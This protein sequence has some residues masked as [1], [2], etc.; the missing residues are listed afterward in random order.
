[1]T[2]GTGPR[3]NEPGLDTGSSVASVRS[4][5]DRWSP[6]YDWNP[7][8]ALVRPA[9]RRAVTAMA[10]SA[11]DTV[12]DMGTG[13]GANLPLLREAVGPSGHVIGVDVSPGMLNRAR[14]RVDRSGWRNVTLVEGDIREPP[15]EGPVAGI[16]S[17]FVVVIY[18]DPDRLIESWV[19]RLNPGTVANLYAGP[20]GRWYGPAV[21]GLLSVYLRVF[22]EGW[23]LTGDGP[24]PLRVIASRGERARTALA[25]RSE[26][27]ETDDLAFG[28]VTLD[29]GRIGR[30]P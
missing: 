26:G 3:A 6:V 22:E 15:V 16:L 11:G 27:F 24:N 29:V 19:D 4:I 9:R 20:S 12:V 13:T 7:A 25:G 30:D 5:Y 28:L 21:N 14:R 23:S 10:L 18:A 2:G 17:A 1:M 8:L